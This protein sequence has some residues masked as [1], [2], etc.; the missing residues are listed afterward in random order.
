MFLGGIFGVEPGTLPGGS[1]PW[2]L[3]AH[4]LCQPIQDQT[5]QP[6]G[7]IFIVVPPD[8]IKNHRLKGVSH[9]M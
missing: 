3:P 8:N 5:N 1:I 2:R 4:L 9:D 6:A 7:A